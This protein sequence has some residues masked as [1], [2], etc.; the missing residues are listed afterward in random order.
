MTN[1]DIPDTGLKSKASYEAVETGKVSPL[2]KSNERPRGSYPAEFKFEI[3]MTFANSSNPV[4]ALVAF[5]ASAIKPR[6]AAVL[7][8]LSNCLQT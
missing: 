4:M 6:V 7:V 2:V 3:R 1:I 8:A 5:L